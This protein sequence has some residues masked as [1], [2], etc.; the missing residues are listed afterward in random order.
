MK[1]GEM[2]V[3]SVMMFLLANSA[4]AQHGAV[5]V[6][7]TVDKSKPGPEIDRNIYGQFA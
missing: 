1:L 7:V 3:G 2:V 5:S 6:A 4:V